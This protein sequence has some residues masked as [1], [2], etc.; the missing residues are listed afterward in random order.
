MRLRLPC[1][2]SFVLASPVPV[3]PAPPGRPRPAPR[4]ARRP[5]PVVR[6]LLG[7][8]ALALA[9]VAGACNPFAPGLD[10]GAALTPRGD[11]RSVDGFLAAFRSAYDL[12]DAAL[13]ESLLD[14]AFTFVYYDDGAQVERQWTFSQDV[15]ATRRLF[16]AARE[17]RLRWNAVLLLDST[18]TTATVVRGFDLAVTLAADGAEVR[19]RGN[20]NFRL[21]RA[22][23]GRPGRLLR[24]RDESEL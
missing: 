11:P 4:P 5:P 15:D 8:V 12:R 7:A 13:Y 3:R 19:T 18:A 10:D 22:A 2:A 17:V 1:P 20:V 9:L 24:R 21:T 14:S 6:R 23:A 16:A